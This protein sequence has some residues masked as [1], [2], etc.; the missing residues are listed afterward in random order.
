MFTAGVSPAW[1]VRVRWR[2]KPSQSTA[3][4]LVNGNRMADMPV[5]LR[6]G[7]SRVSGS[8]SEAVMAIV[9]WETG[10]W[11]EAGTLVLLALLAFVGAP[12]CQPAAQTPAPKL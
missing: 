9:Y 5:I 1:A 4:V 11:C 6:R 7:R 2:V 10:P 3:L 12:G 8:G